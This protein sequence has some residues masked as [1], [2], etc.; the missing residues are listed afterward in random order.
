MCRNAARQGKIQGWYEVD[1]KGA[2]VSKVALVAFNGEMTCFVHVLL[3]GLNM[4]EKGFELKI[5]LEGAATGLIPELISEQNPFNRLYLQVKDKGLIDAVC[6]ACSSKMGSL[7]AAVDEGLPIVDE[8][9]GHPSMGRY[10]EDGYT[11]VTF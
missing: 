1:P 5:I 9:S 10:I 8:M 2:K 6:K 4:D 3:N 7:D 11:I